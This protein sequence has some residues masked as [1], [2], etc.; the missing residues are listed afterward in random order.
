M[1]VRS[2]LLPC[3]CAAFSFTAFSQEPKPAPESG[4]AWKI[5][6][7]A[8][9]PDGRPLASG[10]RDNTIRLWDVA[11]G[12]E[13]FTLTGPTSPTEPIASNPDVSAN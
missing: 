12:Y 4:P 1:K 11:T 9:S 3:I 2:V 7:L 13:V 6:S 5:I 8:F 10:G